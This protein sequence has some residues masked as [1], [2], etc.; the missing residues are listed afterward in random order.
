MRTAPLSLGRPF[1]IR[2]RVDLSWFVIALLVTAGTF[3]TFR[4]AYP[5]LALSTVAGMSVATTVL[6]VLSLLSHEIA[7]ALVARRLGIPVRGITLFLFGGVSEISH[8]VPDPRDEFAIALVGPLVSVFLGGVM[9]TV[10][11]L[12]TRLGIDQVEGVATSLAGVN[13]VLALFN[14][15]P[16]LPLD[17]GRLLRSGIW[18][19]TGNRARSTRV[20]VAGGRLAALALLVWGVVRV[21]GG[22][23]FGLWFGFVALFLDAS[24]RASGRVTPPGSEGG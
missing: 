2:L 18:K 14:L 6:F 23:V 24:A 1:G 3:S 20:A 22:D 5:H 11:T 17:G 4:G 13:G 8:D 16:G 10:S 7:H 19:L 12:A 15:V 9:V 21:A